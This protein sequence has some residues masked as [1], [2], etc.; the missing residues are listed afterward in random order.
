MGEADLVSTVERTLGRAVFRS[1]ASVTT[2]SP[3]GAPRFAKVTGA[4]G[5]GESGRF[6]AHIAIRGVDDKPIAERTL[7]TEGECGR[8]DESIAVVVTLM[9]DGV[10]ETPTPLRIP[11]EPPRVAP[12]AAPAPGPRLTL[13]FGGGAGVSYGLLPGVAVSGGMRGELAVRRFVPIALTLRVY[14]GSTATLSGV[15][16]RFTA[17]TGELE[18]CPAWSGPRVRLGGCA[19]IGAGGLLGVYVN[20]SEGQSHLRPLVLA[21]LVPFAAVRLAGPVWA[22]LAAGAWIPFLRER[23]GY[24]DAGGSFETVFRPA[25]VVPTGTLTLE[26]QGGS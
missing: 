4:V 16:G 15:G 14:P 22:R 12:P 18:A 21:T 9:I 8:L 20:L 26:V 13:A 7:T 5:R 24:V 3:V 19:G 10:E 6:E 2:G 23:W 25:P 11:A 1:D 17:W